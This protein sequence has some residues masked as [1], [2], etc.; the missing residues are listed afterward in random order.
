MIL[1]RDRLKAGQKRGCPG[2]RRS[3]DAQRWRAG[4]SQRIDDLR[5]DIAFAGELFA[6][7]HADVDRVDAVGRR[8]GERFACCL[9][10]NLYQRTGIFAELGHA[11]AADVNRM[12][13]AIILYRGL[14]Y[15]YEAQGA[16]KDKMKNSHRQ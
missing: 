13:S 4:E 10:K 3:F 1:R 16:R 14:N 8:S 6:V 11:D 12:H 7:H 15:C 9:L 5:R 2:G